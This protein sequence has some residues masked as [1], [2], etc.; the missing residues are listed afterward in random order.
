MLLNDLMNP[1]TMQ[2]YIDSLFVDGDERLK[3][4]NIRCGKC[5]SMKT[6]FGEGALEGVLLPI[7]CKCEERADKERRQRAI[8][9]EQERRRKELRRF[10][11]TMRAYA[12]KTFA[13][14]L[15][16]ESD[17]SITCRRYCENWEWIKRDNI[18]L[19]FYGDVGTGKSFYACCIANEIIDRYF[20]QVYVTTIPRLISQLQ[21]FDGRETVGA[22]I[23]G[24]PL[25]VLDDLG[26]ERETS[27]AD[28]QLFSIIDR[29]LL[30]SKPT[31]ITTNLTDYEIENPLTLV[32]RR[33]FDRISEMCPIQL[34]C[35]GRNRRKD[36]MSARRE[37][38]IEALR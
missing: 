34:R 32:Q 31:I 17:V 9:Y 8:E 16:P 13:A 11:F 21:P 3:D 28:E 20:E 36:A 23:D 5:G 6:C 2:S 15:A 4:G 37:Q 35:D 25:L 27:F 26:A 18:G 29:R 38:A 22:I 19:L 24:A 30:A 7:R 1:E 33:I 12:N 14:D 10:G